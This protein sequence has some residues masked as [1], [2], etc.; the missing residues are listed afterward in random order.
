MI[1]G[2]VFPLLIEILTKSDFKT[3]KEAAWAV[4]NATSG[5]SSQQIRYI[6]SQ[7]ALPALCDL[8]S[9]HDAKIVIVALTGIENILR[10]GNEIVKES[11]AGTHNPYAIQVE[12]CFGL[13]KIEYLQEH[14]NEEIYRK[15][16]DIIETYF[17]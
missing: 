4:T 8:L 10:I 13:D 1:D 14:E 7:D 11:G 5:G 6:A 3:R 12:E 2:N 17:K 16:F 15:A 9:V